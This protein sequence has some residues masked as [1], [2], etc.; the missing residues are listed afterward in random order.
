MEAFNARLVI[1]RKATVMLLEINFKVIPSTA[2][3]EA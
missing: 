1:I 3:A 2:K